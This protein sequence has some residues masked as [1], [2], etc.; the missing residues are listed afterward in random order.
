MYAKILVPVDGSPTSDLG[1]AE[2]IKLARLTGARLCL[3]HA[4]DMLSLSMTAEASMLSSP[5]LFELLRESGQ[6]IVARAKAQAAQAG[7]AAETVLLDR[8]GTRVA[9]LVVDESRRWGAEL[10]V[11]G[12]HGRRGVGRL[13]MGS[14][15]EQIVRHA[16][17]PVLLVRAPAL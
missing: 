9:D 4:V 17:V 6:E 2:A 1:L 13:V 16:P 11:I 3:L 12:T 5:T 14:D 8:L 15:A 10:I 7:I